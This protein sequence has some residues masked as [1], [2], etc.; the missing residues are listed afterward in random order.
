MRSK[1]SFLFVGIQFDESKCEFIL[2]NRSITES[3]YTKGHLFFCKQRQ[4]F[5]TCNQIVIH[6][7]TTKY[8]SLK[9]VPTWPFVF[10][11]QN[12]KFWKLYPNNH[13][14]FPEGNTK[15]DYLLL[16]NLVLR[17]KIEKEFENMISRYFVAFFYNKKRN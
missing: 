7:I 15:S 17:L 9:V 11:Q 13:L 16:V 2:K 10:L 1:F 4:N 6:V 12:T 5:E 8:R 14:Y 3:V